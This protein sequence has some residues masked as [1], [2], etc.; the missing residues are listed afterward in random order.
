MS[1]LIG[2]T[3]DI[4]IKGDKMFRALFFLTLYVLYISNISCSSIEQ[5]KVTPYRDWK[6]AIKAEDVFKN[7]VH[8]SYLKTFDNRLFWLEVRPQE[9]GRY[10]VVKRG[11]DGRTIDLTPKGYSAR[12]RVHEYGGSS[13][14]VHGNNLYFVNFKDQRIYWQDLDHPEKVQAIT[15]AKNS[16]GSLGKY[17]DLTLSPDG[18]WLV[19]V[20]EKEFKEREN[21]N[22]LAAILTGAKK[23]S[24][25]QIIAKGA[26]FYKSPTFS[27]DGKS[28]AWTQW[29]HPY[30]R[31]Y[32]TELFLG[33]FANGRIA[34]R[35][36]ITGGDQTSIDS[37]AF[38]HKGQLH[39]SM[40]FP[41]QADKS[42]KNFYNIYKF[43]GG[44]VK[45]I[46]RE[47][48]EFAKIQFYDR[49]LL[50]THS[51]EGKIS[52][53]AVD[54]VTGKA[55]DFNTRY[56]LYQDIAVSSSGDI[57]SIVYSSADT[58]RIINLKTGEIIKVAFDQPLDKKNISQA[59][60]V[61]FPT[62]DGDFA[63]G[64][65]Y[66]PK[67]SR[68]KAPEGERP[69]VRILVHGG[70]TH[71]TS[72][73][74]SVSKH[75]WL[76][77]GYALFDINYRGSTGYGRRYR[78]A[79]LKKWGIIDAQDVKDGLQ[80]LKSKKIVGEKAFIAGG[81]A[82]GYS[83]QRL[84]TLFPDLFDGGASYAGIGNLVTL[85][86][87]THKYES[88]YLHQLIG[89]SLKTHGKEYEKRSPINHLEKLKAPM[90]IFQGAD[91]KV[92]P[93]ENGREMAQI[94]KKRGVYHE[95]YEYPG[96]GHGFRKKENMIH[97]LK[98]ESSFFKKILH[99]QV[100]LKTKG[101]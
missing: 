28:L 98:K 67:N 74:F 41:R 39:F 59:K 66:L 11:K 75:Y 45:P 86:K 25:P 3:V 100:S 48:S 10:V 4:E 89:G 61:K 99:N 97:A 60:S 49:T 36:R 42:A 76:T 71:R 55:S 6:P 47:L 94:L 101:P 92:V 90:A 5:A 83:V 23:T 8:L 81:S 79:L 58:P 56:A 77:Q 44:K 54:P 17:M 95:Y 32:S 72:P 20:Y 62:S 27:K 9:E 78:D 63:Y 70:P 82:G 68:Y 38:D 46:T 2:E 34:N 96:E 24:K 84:L 29:N 18:Q 88:R 15:P 50:A 12:S 30:M 33:S 22:Y 13:Y 31:W 51:A 7:F 85:Q 87:L 73:L 1:R 53:K 52:L 80:Y 37:F 19:F 43:E 69:P 16:D 57:Y 64:Y 26:D 40:D 14:A 21:Q 93:P 35:K 65:L 91:D